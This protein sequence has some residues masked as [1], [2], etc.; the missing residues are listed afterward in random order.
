MIIHMVD[1]E[2]KMNLKDKQMPCLTCRNTFKVTPCE[3]K[4]GIINTFNLT[5]YI[6]PESSVVFEKTVFKLFKNLHDR[7]P[8]K[9]CLVKV[10]CKHGGKCPPY[11]KILYEIS[12]C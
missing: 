7:C 3:H 2:N 12:F 1:I 9:E 6:L 8:C 10:M 4:D 11:H 5:S